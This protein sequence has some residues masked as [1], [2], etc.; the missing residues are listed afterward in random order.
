MILLEVCQVGFD[1]LSG[2][3]SA[4]PLLSSV[5]LTLSAGKL[6]HLTGEN[7]RGKTTLLKLLAGI[8]LPQIGEIRF[9]GINIHH[10]LS[11]Y[12]THLTYVGHRPGF[13][14][15]LT[16]L[17]NCYYDLKCVETKIA[18]DWLARFNL[19][20]QQHQTTGLLSAGQR[21]RLSLLRLFLSNT[22]LWIIDEPLVGLDTHSIGVFL[23]C[24]ENHLQEGGMAIL[25][26]HQP[27]GRS[28]LGYEEYRIC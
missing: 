12:Q 8:L 1:Y 10:Q 9:N 11:C 2:L 3:E 25:T 6:L 18:L 13:S 17:E 4:E 5:S 20:T 7:G 15:A 26:S 28:I 24:L 14:H 27:L 19:L 22:Q 21:R 23:D 16:V